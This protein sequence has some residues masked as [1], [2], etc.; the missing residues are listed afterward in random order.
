MIGMIVLYA[1][2]IIPIGWYQTDCPK[3]Y[4]LGEQYGGI[5]I[6]RIY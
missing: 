6:V 1:G 4:K 3:E 5:C 2:L